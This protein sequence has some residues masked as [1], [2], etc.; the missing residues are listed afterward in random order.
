[1]LYDMCYYCR[2][3]RNKSTCLTFFRILYDTELTNCTQHGIPIE[4]SCRIAKRHISEFNDQNGGLITSKQLDHL[5]YI[6]KTV[7]NIRKHKTEHIFNALEISDLE[8]ARA[9]LK[10]HDSRLANQ[11][12]NTES[13]LR[14]DV[15][16]D[17]IIHG[18]ETGLT[19]SEIAELAEVSIRTVQRH[20]RSIEKAKV[21]KALKSPRSLNEIEEITGLSPDKVRNYIIEINGSLHATPY[22][23]AYI[24]D[25]I[26]NQ[27]DDLL[28]QGKNQQ[29]IADELGLSRQTINRRIQKHKN[30]F[31]DEKHFRDEQIIK[32][33][34]R[35]KMP[36]RR[37]VANMKRRYK[38]SVSVSTVAH[39][40][41]KAEL[42]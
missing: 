28:M 30:C 38:I 34:T 5:C 10:V 9:R 11:S 42:N 27:I 25:E 23:K 41:S 37:I 18:M 33:R 21:E 35:Y 24:P 20:I 15:K 31:Y 14:K 7:E 32:Y 3:L 1:M 39:V 26:D 8:R 36:Y 29:E 19:N 17:F 40:C 16:M 12:R 22:A 6:P 2:F 13:R 4:Q